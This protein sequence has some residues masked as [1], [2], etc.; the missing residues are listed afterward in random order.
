[1]SLIPTNFI[2]IPQLDT[3]TQPQSLKVYY[4]SGE[5][6]TIRAVFRGC[7][8]I[9]TGEI[10]AMCSVPSSAETGELTGVWG[11]M[12]GLDPLCVVVDIMGGQVLYN[13]RE[14]YDRMPSYLQ[15]ELDKRPEW[16][17]L[18]ELAGESESQ[19]VL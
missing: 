18:L 8:G 9:G 17:A 3:T 12:M 11:E 6:H 1:M 16:P 13:P 4:P 15:G 5:C 10:F 7:F 14:L 19:K 2:K